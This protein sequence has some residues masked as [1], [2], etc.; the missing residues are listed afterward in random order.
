MDLYFLKNKMFYIL[1]HLHSNIHNLFFHMKYVKVA[2]IK[3]PVSF[4]TKVWVGL[5]LRQ[6]ERE[7]SESG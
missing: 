1:L 6:N 7:Y 5:M 3:L 4:G 2:I